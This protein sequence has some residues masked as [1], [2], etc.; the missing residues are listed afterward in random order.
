MFIGFYNQI[1]MPL[2]FYLTNMK[3]IIFS[4]EVMPW[5]EMFKREP[6]PDRIHANSIIIAP[7][8][9]DGCRS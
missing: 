8:A 4:N 1:R 3:K 6:R 2:D 9:D 5:T 7:D